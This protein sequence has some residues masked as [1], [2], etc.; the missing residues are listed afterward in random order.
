MALQKKVR[1][2]RIL[3]EKEIDLT[4][5]EPTE[6]DI[7]RIFRELEAKEDGEYWPEDEI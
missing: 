2:T 4:S 3:K 7:E 5:D 6:D 1:K